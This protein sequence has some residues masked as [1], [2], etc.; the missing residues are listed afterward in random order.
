MC[1]ELPSS[2]IADAKDMLAHFQLSQIPMSNSLQV[3]RAQIAR[4]K[5]YREFA[6][7]LYE[8]ATKSTL[9]GEMLRQYLQTIRDKFLVEESRIDAMNN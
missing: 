3:D 8:I 5:L 2:I 9:R 1:S 4:E 7:H 6:L